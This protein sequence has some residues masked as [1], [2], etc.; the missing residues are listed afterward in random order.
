MRAIT[1][2]RQSSQ[3]NGEVSVKNRE[4]ETTV[5]PHRLTCVKE[6]LPQQA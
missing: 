5:E 1:C 4:T 6:S 3:A 2:A